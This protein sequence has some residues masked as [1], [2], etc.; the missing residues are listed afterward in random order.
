MFHR[1]SLLLI[2]VLLL[3]LCSA[4]ATRPRFRGPMPVRNQHPAQL[5]VLHMDPAGASPL[6]PGEVGLRVD[7][8][9]TSLFL[10][11]MGGGN[12][13]EM[14]GEIM[15]AAAKARIGVGHALELAVEL[16]VVYT[17]GGFLDGF[18]IDW[19]DLW[20]L[21]SQGRPTAPRNGFSVN[22]QRQ[23]TTVFALEERSLELADVPVALSWAFVPLT[24][25]RP[26]GAALRAAVE[27][28]TGDEDAGVGNGEFD[29]S[30]GLTGELRWD[31]VA[32][33]GHVQHTFAGTP[34]QAAAGGLQFGDVT[35]AGVG[36]EVALTDSL[37]ALLQTELETSTLRGLGFDRVSDIQWLLWT[38][39]RA[40]LAPGVALEF[41]LGEDLSSFIA[42][43]F[44]AYVGLAFDL[45]RP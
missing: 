1:A 21:P 33:T 12:H 4:C 9:Y 38:G 24:D 27:L 26:F 42:P 39:A 2:I 23:G 34:A 10:A 6:G 3:P 31:L 18:L 13:F 22:A 43:D 14:D 30:L 41:G 19:H 29:W 8:A 17:T 40:Q 45:G 44:T 36:V 25:D 37:A 35:S 11:G 20:G 28:P 16:P 7:T 15:R 32:M 5:T